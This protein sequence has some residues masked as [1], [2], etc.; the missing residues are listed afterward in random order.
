MAIFEL[1]VVLFLTFRA[2][3]QFILFSLF[4]TILELAISSPSVFGCV[5]PVS[6]RFRRGFLASFLFVLWGAVSCPPSHKGSLHPFQGLK[7]PSSFFLTPVGALRVPG[8]WMPPDHLP[9]LGALGEGGTSLSS[10]C[11]FPPPTRLV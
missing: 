6:K 7:G 8:Q 9:D 10:V 4:H 11:M 5:L 3:N 2:K 1:F